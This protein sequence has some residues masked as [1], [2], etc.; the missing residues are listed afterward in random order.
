[1]KQYRRKSLSKLV[2]E[3]DINALAS[4]FEELVKKQKYN[5]KLIKEQTV[6]SDSELG[7]K[8]FAKTFA[9]PRGSVGGRSK[10]M[11]D[12]LTQL[13]PDG[14]V[15]VKYVFNDV[16]LLW[17]RIGMAWIIFNHLKHIMKSNNPNHVLTINVAIVHLEW[18]IIRFIYNI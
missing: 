2:P 13:G 1:M 14:R 17:F 18:N 4:K 12:N 6:E 16:N 7:Y 10:L 15:M 11:R 8:K 3:K 5:E 9:K